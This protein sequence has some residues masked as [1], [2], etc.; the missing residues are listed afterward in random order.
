MNKKALQPI[1]LKAP[2]HRLSYR[3]IYG[4]TDTGG[5][6]YYGNYLRFF[7]IGRTEFLRSMLK[8]SYRDLEQEGLILPVSE[9]YCR[10]KAPANYDDLLEVST[11][12]EKSSK[13]SIRFHYLIHRLSD[14]RLL[15][16]GYTVHAATDRSGHLTRIPKDFQ[17]ALA[18]ICNK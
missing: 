14:R 12:L 10:Y 6:V 8:T 18:D 9:A 3:V 4:D 17:T 2:I 1:E 7:E 5:V 16:M 13:F 11:S 15:V